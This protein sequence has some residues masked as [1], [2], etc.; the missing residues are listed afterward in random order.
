MVQALFPYELPA[1]STDNP[2]FARAD[3][4]ANIADALRRQL[5]VDNVLAELDYLLSD[6]RGRA[7]PLY[8][9]AQ[10]CVTVGTTVET[11][12]RPWMSELVG[13]G[14]ESWLQT[15]IENVLAR[16]MGED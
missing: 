14:L 1:S 2:E 3:A 5:D 4:R 13:S 10:H 12:Q 11:G 15:A 7:H 8:A 9:L 6:L 16:A